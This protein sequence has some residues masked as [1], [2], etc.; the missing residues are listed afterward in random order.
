M[1]QN[2]KKDVK[3]FFNSLTYHCIMFEKSYFRFKKL[4]IRPETWPFF[5]M[6]A[7]LARFLEE[8]PSGLAQARLNALNRG[9]LDTENIWFI[10]D[11]DAELKKEYFQ[12]LKLAKAYDLQ[13]SL[14]AEPHEAEKHVRA[15]LEHQ[16][17]ASEMRSLYD[18]AAEHIPILNERINNKDLR[19]K[20]IKGWPHLSDLIS[21]FNPGRITIISA[22]TGFGKTNLLLNLAINASHDFKTAIFNMEMITEDIL[23]RIFAIKTKT[24]TRN[25]QKG[26]IDFP[27]LYDRLTENNVKNLHLTDGKNLSVDEIYA[28]LYQLK[29]K[30]GVDIAFVDYDQ[31]L[32]VRVDSKTPEWKALQVA[33]HQLE[34]VAKELEVHIV[35]LS[36]ASTEGLPSGSK[37]SMYP[38]SVV[39]YFTKEEEKFCLKIIKNRFGPSN[40]LIEVQYE[41]DKSIIREVG[42]MEVIPKEKKL[43]RSLF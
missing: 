30:E 3:L 12:K 2:T 32:D 43:S 34:S 24:K 17:S 14:N 21:G 7:A 4:G 26:E 23:D 28:H 22:L 31:K 11:D 5:A 41:P 19:I 6:S 38:S 13:Q 39:I 18:L 33:V 42:P 27:I 37:R 10:P 29:H 9:D 20:S 40:T 15:F 1:T 36:Q 8:A 25:I 16:P 35:L